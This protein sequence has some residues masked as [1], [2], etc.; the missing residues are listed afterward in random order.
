MSVLLEQWIAGRGLPGTLVIDG[1]VHIGGWAGKTTFRPGEEADQAQAIMDAHGVDAVCAMG[2]GFLYG[3]CDYRLGNDFLL[4]VWRRM[5]ERLIP[6]ACYNPNDSRANLLAEL[7]R[8]LDAG[9]R[10]IK[11]INA[12][13]ENYPGDGPNLMALYEFAAVHNLLVLNHTWDPDVLLRLAAEFPTLPFILGHYFS[14]KGLEEPIAERPNVY[15]N[16]WDLGNLGWL[17]RGLARLGAA[18][19]LLGS[20]GFLNPLSAG[21]GPVVF[22]PLPDAE[23]RRILGL[24]MA[25]LLEQAAAL[26]P[27]LRRQWQQQGEQTA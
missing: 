25:R 15:V 22:A 5:P 1:H 10:G 13:Q 4:E 26:P 23:K 24:T 7:R 14:G 18:K 17:D 27:R 3:A 8:M 20:D 11:L 9:V 16:V 2:G 21:I 19:F 12:Y 6:F